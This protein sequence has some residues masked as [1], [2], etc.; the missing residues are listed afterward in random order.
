MFSLGDALNLVLLIFT[1]GNLPTTLFSLEE[2]INP[3]FLY[4][5]G[6]GGKNIPVGQFH[7]RVILTTR[8]SLLAKLNTVVRITP[9]KH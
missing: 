1:P 4:G 3:M 5:C 9:A 8:F 6:C 2:E 7:R